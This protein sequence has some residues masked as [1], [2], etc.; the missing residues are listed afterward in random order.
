[1]RSEPEIRSA[2][3]TYVSRHAGD[4]AFTD[5]TA[6]FSVRVLRSIHL[7]ELI[8]LLE[9]LRGA[10]IDVEQLRIGDFDSIDAMLTRFGGPHA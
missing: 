4:V 5:Q 3:R 9:R 7:P 8:M 1:M 2:L 6:L 10:P